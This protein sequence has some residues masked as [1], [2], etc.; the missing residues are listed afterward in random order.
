MRI[1]IVEDDVQLAQTL[2]RALHQAEHSAEYVHKAEQASVVL[3]REDFDLVILDW[4]LPGTSGLQFLRGLRQKSV[5]LPVL[6]LTA[7]VATEAKVTGLDAGADD[8]LV[9]PF[10][11]DELMARVR[12]LGRRPHS[13]PDSRISYGQLTLDIDLNQL[14]AADRTFDL[15]VQ[16]A[17]LLKLLLDYQGGYVSKAR[18]ES[19]LSSWDEPVTMNAI[20]ALISRLRKKIGESHIKTLRGVGYKVNGN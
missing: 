5:T 20:E 17:R 6:M 16:E 18:I 7:N 11:L 10:D 12:V 14:H 1:L 3:A 9:K 19:Y 15:S 13:R 2:K 4:M 8:Y